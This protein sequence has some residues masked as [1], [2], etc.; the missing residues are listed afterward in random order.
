MMSESVENLLRRYFGFCDSEFIFPTSKKNKQKI[1]D[2]ET[3]LVATGYV[4]SEPPEDNYSMH[5]FRLTRKGK[6][7]IA[8]L[9]VKWAKSA[10]ASLSPESMELFKAFLEDR[11]DAIDKDED[12]DILDELEFAC[13]INETCE[14]SWDSCWWYYE[15]TEKGALARDLLKSD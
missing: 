6:V 12:E 9:R 2:V 13:L 4:I 7:V 5:W 10:L 11:N 1:L 14:E 3:S 8:E 15:L